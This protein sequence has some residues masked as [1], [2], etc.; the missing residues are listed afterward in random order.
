[1]SETR[2]FRVI[3]EEVHRWGV[4]RHPPVDV[5]RHADLTGVTFKDDPIIADWWMT[6]DEPCTDFW[7][8]LTGEDKT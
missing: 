6:W 7:D 8:H 1:M 3:V 4:D 5:F 2:H